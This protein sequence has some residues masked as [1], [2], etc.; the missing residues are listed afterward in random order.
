MKAALW[1]PIVLLKVVASAHF[2]RCDSKEATLYYLDVSLDVIKA[3]NRSFLTPFFQ[4]GYRICRVQTTD[5][6]QLQKL[7]NQ[8]TTMHIKSF[9]YVSG[10]VINSLDFFTEEQPHKL[11]Y[12]KLTDLSIKYVYRMRKLGKEIAH[13]YIA[14]WHY[15]ITEG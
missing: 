3:F 7:T 12:L 15:A 8:T 2:D 5:L 6:S 13:D 10:S 11:F 14:K 1:L 4:S 9:A